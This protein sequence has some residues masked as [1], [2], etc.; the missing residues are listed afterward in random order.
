MSYYFCIVGT[1]DNPIYQ[2]D[3]VSKPI[4]SSG[5]ASFF[6]S[7]SISSS[8]TPNSASSPSGASYNDQR[9]SVDSSQSS[10]STLAGLNSGG[11]I[12]GGVFGF[13]TALGALAGGLSAARDA[14]N[15][16]YVGSAPSTTTGEGKGLGF[17][18]YNDKDV[19][20]MIAHSSLDAV[21]DRQFVNG[22]M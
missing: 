4:T 2:A 22:A 21:E 9:G 10:Q 3:L 16:S 20:Q 8:S 13:G 1:R 5:P 11:A 12:G 6:T 18:R 15:S 19:L 17:G 14:R 7:S